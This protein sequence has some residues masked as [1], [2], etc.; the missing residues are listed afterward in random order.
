MNE[1]YSAWREKRGRKTEIGVNLKNNIST[2]QVSRMLL[3]CLV[4]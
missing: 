2:N 3:K 4:K 1:S